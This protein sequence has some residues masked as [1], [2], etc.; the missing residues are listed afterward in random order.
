MIV[1]IWRLDPMPGK[2]KELI[3]AAT[4]ILSKTRQQ[5]GC[6]FHHLCQDLENDQRFIIIQEWDNQSDL[7][8]YWCNERFGAFLGMFHLLKRP[9]DINIHAVSLTAGMETIKATRK[10]FQRKELSQ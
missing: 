2:R 3:Q 10:K 4:D 9:P 8:A 6:R 5:H 7:D 1:A